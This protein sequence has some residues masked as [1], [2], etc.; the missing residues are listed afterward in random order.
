VA[1]SLV[2]IAH[3]KAS[4]MRSESEEN[5]AKLQESL[6]EAERCLSWPS[7]RLRD[8]WHQVKELNQM[9][10]ILSPVP[11][12]ERARI[13]A[14]VNDLCEEA[15]RIREGQDN[16]SRIKR[17]CVES[18]IEEA[19]VYTKGDADDLRKAHELLNEALRWMKD[20]W[21]EFNL[22]TQLL[23]ISSGK[24]NHA[25]HETCWKKWQ[26]VKEEVRWKRQEL[27]E[28]S[29]DGLRSDAMEASGNAE[30][31]PRLAKDQVKSIQ[32][33]MSGT[34]MSKEQFGEIRHILDSV[35]HR[36]T[37]ANQHRREDWRER[38]LGRV[39]QKRTLIEQKEALIER[40]E[41]QI[42]KCREQEESART[43][44]FAERVRGW[45][46]EKQGIIHSAQ[47]FIDKLEQEIRE[48]E[49]RLE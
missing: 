20:G 36:A 32:A 25:D 44:E 22:T 38:Q 47:Q 37:Q 23:T 40:L 33:K 31:N 46:E 48:I 4:Q 39:A 1:K 11:P 27:A 49:E 5:L 10:R 19:R 34:F 35:W 29:F 12:N 17:E 9:I 8:F 7:I 28:S 30:T 41:E 45:I 13:R 14:K 15:K 3:R 21:S 18:K 16:D 26:E 43:E 2:S 6:D 24:M 42:E